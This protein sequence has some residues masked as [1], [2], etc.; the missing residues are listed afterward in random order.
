MKGDTALLLSNPKFIRFA[1]ARFI[2]NLGNGMGPVALAF[3]ILG[4]AGRTGSDLSA[5]LFAQGLP[6]IALMLAAGVLGDRVSRSFLMGGSDIV[7]AFV[8]TF[9]GYLFLKDNA[10]TLRLVLLS[11]IVGT[12]HAIWWPAAAGILQIVVKKE[13]LQSANSLVMLSSNFGFI[14]GA[15]AGAYIV[16]YFGTSTALFIDALTFFIAGALVV[17]MKLPSVKIENSEKI[18]VYKDFREGFKLA[19]SLQWF[20]VI[21]ICFAFINLVF[22]ATYSILGPLSFNDTYGDIKSAA[23]RWSLVI[24]AVSAGMLLGSYFAL[25]IRL[26]RPLKTTMLFLLTLATFVLALGMSAPLWIILLLGVLS[27]IALDIFQIMWNTILSTI[28][29]PEKLSRISSFDSFGSYV[30]YPFGIAIAGPISDY[31]GAQTALITGAGFMYIFTLAALFFPS[32]RNLENPD[33]LYPS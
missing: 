11:L 29:A 10:T 19:R 24:S 12:L 5:V 30:L 28:V 2:S 8:V 9:I 16:A 17:S 33:T 31:I 13:E 15:G 25:K 20:F 6:T 26:K 21:V 18:N 22:E 7:L 14:A 3:G 32:V 1:S 4:L 23:S 27:G